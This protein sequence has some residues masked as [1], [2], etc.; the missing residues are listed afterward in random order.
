MARTTGVSV[1]NKFLNGLVTEA[2][3]L[4]FPGGSV[5]ETDNVRYTRTAKASRRF[6]FDAETGYV[7]DTVTNNSY[8]IKTFFWK[9]IGE[10]GDNS[11]LVRQVGNTINFFRIATDGSVSPNKHTSSVNIVDFASSGSGNHNL[12]ECDFSSGYGY[13]FVAHKFI[14]PFYVLY[15]SQTDE[16]TS[17][18]IDIQIR[19]FDGLEDNLDVK[20]RPSTLTDTHKYNL[21]NQGWAPFDAGP[22][23]T[24]WTFIATFSGYFPP[25]PS[26][27]GDPLST[28]FGNRSDYP[29]NADVW[30]I[31]KDTYGAFNPKST[32]Q[33][34][35]G[36]SPAPKGHYILNPFYKDRTSAVEDSVRIQNVLTTV[37]IPSLGIESS[38]SFRPKTIGF[39]GGR[40]WYG[41]V[42]ANGYSN[43]LYFSQVV[44]TEK[45]FGLCYQ[46]ND[47]TSES[48][49]DILSTDGGEISILDCASIIK[50]FTYQNS[51]L[52]FATNG[53]WSISGSQGV[54]FSAT[55]YSISKLSST[56]SLSNSSF[57]DAGG[58]PVWWNAEGIYTIGGNATMAQSSVNSISDERIK[59][60]FIDEIPDN[61]KFYA[62]GDY[63]PRAREMQWLFR[64]TDPTT[65]LENYSFDRIL[66]Y[67]IDTK[68]FYIFSFDNSLVQINSIN[69]IMGKGS[70]YIS[71]IV[72]DGSN[73]VVTD[74]PGDAVTIT[75]IN[76]SQL[77]GKFK[78][79]ISHLVSGTSYKFTFSDEHR[80]DYK[81]WYFYDS[82]GSERTAYCITGYKVENEGNKPFQNNYSFIFV[83]NTLAPQF[84][85][86]GVWN[87]G[88]DVSSNRFTNSQLLNFNTQ[89]RDYSFRKI[90]VR[91]SGISL[92]FKFTSK[93]GCAMDIV[94]W[95]NF[96]TGNPYV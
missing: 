25:T 48:L 27:Q 37:S 62:R 91:G 29:S 92:Q 58:I 13:L 94:G 16:F 51:L 28:W 57:I 67:N 34:D 12:Y 1:E 95:S 61:S 6:G 53:V 3:A 38:G 31:L 40:V 30:W 32:V 69:C 70:N 10:N 11:F 17:G 83:D 80:T 56:P 75:D 78:Y 26:I 79:L 44:K 39:F 77:S 49:F 68:G 35:R 47:P 15:D 55:D 82:V 89:Y 19:D 2:S 5:V 64:S 18:Q 46:L 81:D 85:V 71:E 65:G 60:Y 72:Y 21:Y 59:S 76:T 9:N 52:V 93:E 8:A 54:G 63:N 20:D 33:V 96:V 88:N 43:K 42:D 24:P 50:I 14:E 4:N 74:G 86:Q 36:N 22:Y 7:E 41:G 45:E 66:A 90:K 23:T 87:Y 73:A 84:Y